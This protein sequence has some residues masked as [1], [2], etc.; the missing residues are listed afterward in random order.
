[1][2]EKYHSSSK[3][4]GPRAA[5]IF[6]ELNELRR[7]TFTLADVV[8]ITGLSDAAARNLVHKAQQRGLMTR[9]KPGLYNLVPF[10]LGRATEGAFLSR[11]GLQL[12][13]TPEEVD[14]VRLG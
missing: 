3:T 1:M 5:Q 4:L 7:S 9:L 6:T 11:W 8:S 12:N 13:V 2:S 10:E 14:A